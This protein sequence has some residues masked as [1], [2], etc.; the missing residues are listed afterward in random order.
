MFKSTLICI[1]NFLKVSFYLG[2]V[3]VWMFFWASMENHIA[4]FLAHPVRSSMLHSQKSSSEFVLS[5][6]FACQSGTTL[7]TLAGL[8]TP[9]PSSA[10]RGISTME[11]GN[12]KRGQQRNREKLQ[13]RNALPK[14][15]SPLY[16][17]GG[18]IAQSLRPNGRPLQCIAQQL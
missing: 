4:L 13:R 5:L 2:T 6:H 9:L 11:T 7:P 12:W 10:K 18:T 17:R 3:A 1:Y 15:N 14:T 8:R 16:R